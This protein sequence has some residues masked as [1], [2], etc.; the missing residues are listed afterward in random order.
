MD[1][2]FEGILLVLG[3]VG[4][5]CLEECEAGAWRN[6]MDAWR[7]IMGACLEECHGCLHRRV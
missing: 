6:V 4:S 7:S 1:E 2:C 3:G 5:G